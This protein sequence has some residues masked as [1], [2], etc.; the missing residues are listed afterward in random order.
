MTYRRRKYLGPSEAE[1]EDCNRRCMVKPT[2]ISGR[3]RDHSHT[4]LWYCPYR[5]R[6]CLNYTVCSAVY[7][8]HG[9]SIFMLNWINR[10]ITNRRRKIWPM[11]IQ[12]GF[13]ESISQPP[14]IKAWR[15]THLL[16]S[17]LD[18]II[19]R[20]TTSLVGLAWLWAGSDRR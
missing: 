11:K 1:S 15:G 16:H 6:S 14:T 2:V 13:G 19:H 8:Q 18:R 17:V 12:E 9:G 7:G 4:R 3:V 20:L 10:A 5:F